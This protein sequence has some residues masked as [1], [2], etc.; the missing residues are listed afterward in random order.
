MVV[1][2]ID[3]T[4]LEAASIVA[5]RIRLESFMLEVRSEQ[6]LSRYDVSFNDFS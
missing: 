6:D 5:P 4:D 3:E 1:S 2:F